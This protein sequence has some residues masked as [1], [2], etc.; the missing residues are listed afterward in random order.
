M[1]VQSVGLQVEGIM[2]DKMKGKELVDKIDW[3][4][5]GFNTITCKC[6]FS[7]R[8][9]CKIVIE[10]GVMFTVSQDACS[11]C[12]SHITVISARSDPEEYFIRR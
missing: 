11:F 10:D 2:E 6:G 3:K 7:W 12:E 5:L 1:I 4:P 9:K 8:G